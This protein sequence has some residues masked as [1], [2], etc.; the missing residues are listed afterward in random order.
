MNIQ[1]ARRGSKNKSKK[2]RASKEHEYYSREII[3]AYI[4]I[5]NGISTFMCYVML[6]P[7]VYKNSCNTI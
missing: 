6:K 1:T 2:G 3:I 7:S 4:F 5:F